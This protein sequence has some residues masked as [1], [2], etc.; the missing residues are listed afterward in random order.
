MEAA[1]TREQAKQTTV[2]VMLIAAGVI[3]LGNQLDWGPAWSVKRLWP[4]VLIVMGVPSLLFGDEDRNRGGGFCLTM[5]GVIF[6]LHTFQ[7]MSLRQSWPLFVVA[8]GAAMF[9][10]SF[11]KPAPKPKKEV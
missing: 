2:G 4:V 5:S 10:D 1:V 11:T 3:L 9:L 8:G 7:V 6:L